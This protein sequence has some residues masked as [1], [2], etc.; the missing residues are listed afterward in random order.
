M[1]GS[2]CQG[3][4]LP[5]ARRLPQSIG[6]ADDFEFVVMPCPRRM[7]EMKNVIGKRFTGA[8]RVETTPESPVC[9]RQSRGCR[10]EVTLHANFKLPGSVEAGGIHDGLGGRELNMLSSGAVTSLAIDSAW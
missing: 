6:G 5:K 3:V 8:I 4:A 10:F 1:A 9:S 7:I 2:A